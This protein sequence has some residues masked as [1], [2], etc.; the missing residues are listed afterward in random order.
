MWIHVDSAALGDS[1]LGLY[2]RGGV[3][4]IRVDGWEL[5]NGAYHESEDRLGEL[6]AR[7]ARGPDPEV[8]VGGLG[9]GF[10]LA[11]LV[12]H[13]GGAGRVTVAELSDAVI[14]WFDRWTKP[15][16]LG[17]QLGNVRIRHGDV[18]AVAAEGPARDVILLDV[19]N[20]PKPL[21]AAANAALYGL[22]GLGTL[23]RALKA[24]G[25]LMVWSA[26]EDPGF[27][28]RAQAAGFSPAWLPV[29][30]SGGAEPFHVVYVLSV[31]PFPPGELGRFGLQPL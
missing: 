8:L 22:D 9:L 6:A 19:D 11:S 10:T 17:D 3:Y 7:L 2:E 13:L 31:A 18:L 21:S 23:R 30:R 20:G 28:A 26:F 12:R 4:M 24:D 14:R 16:S 15:P 5:M 1:V 25:I 27:V 29:F